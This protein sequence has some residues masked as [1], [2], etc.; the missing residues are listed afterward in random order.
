MDNLYIHFLTIIQETVFIMVYINVLFCDHAER[1]GLG[2]LLWG[3]CGQSSNQEMMICYC[4]TNKYRCLFTSLRDEDHLW[5][6]LL[7]L[8]PQQ[9]RLGKK[10]PSVCL[11]PLYLQ[12]SL[13]K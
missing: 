9:I 10:C 1:H 3:K 11:L 8:A 6:K 4:V 7:Q 12:L 5:L 13:L 2:I